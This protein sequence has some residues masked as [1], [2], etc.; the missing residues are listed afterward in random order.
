MPYRS[1]ADARSILVVRLDALGDVV[2]TG[3][4]LR[5]LRHNAPK[6]RI[7]LV[8]QPSTFNLV[9]LCPYV[10]QVLKFQVNSDHPSQMRL[11]WRFLTFCARHIWTRRWDMAINPRFDVDPYGATLLLWLSR[12]SRRVGYS[13]YVTPGKARHSPWHDRCLT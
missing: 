1:L 4:F 10:D 13:Q 11:A 2:L 7:T 8:V 9:E 12:A 3:P 6:A 5:E